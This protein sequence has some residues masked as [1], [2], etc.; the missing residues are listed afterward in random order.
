[1]CIEQNGNLDFLEVCQDKVNTYLLHNDDLSM[2]KMSK[3]M[4][5]KQYKEIPKAVSTPPHQF[6]SELTPARKR[7]KMLNNYGK[8]PP[9]NIIHTKPINKKLTSQFKTPNRI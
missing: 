5:E 3:Q 6:Q 1:M 2:V 9:L 8:T 7:I 4:I